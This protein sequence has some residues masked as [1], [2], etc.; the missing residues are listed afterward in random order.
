MHPD[1]PPIAAAPDEAAS[2]DAPG[3]PDDEQIFCP[4][5]GYNLTGNPTG[6]CSECGAL[7]SRDQ[8]LTAMKVSADALMPWE[9]R[10]DFG[11]FERFWRTL[12]ISFF[13]PREFAL[14][15]AVQPARTR[16]TSFYA[17]CLVLLTA[18]AT[19]IG[20]IT[21]MAEPGD[22]MDIARIAS[23][24]IFLALPIVPV[25]IVVGLIYASLYPHADR[26]R[27][28]RPWRAILEYATGH[29]LLGAS[30]LVLGLLLVSSPRSETGMILAV[31][32]LSIWIGCSILWAFTLVEIVRWRTASGHR[33]PR[34]L[35]P[36]IVLAWIVW[37]ATL[38]VFLLSVPLLWEL[39]EI[40]QSCVKAFERAAE[41]SL[42]AGEHWLRAA[43]Y[44]LPLFR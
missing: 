39:M 37:V 29:W 2:P 12:R 18:N 41:D 32:V 7:F 36:T 22:S 6:R 8:L 15:F 40:G 9:R 38:Y 1:D 14:A 35:G 26:E 21:E 17:V 33:K 43:R 42:R 11:P 19:A 20:V 3:R 27:H 4:V 23:F 10:D 13:R 44:F 30:A 25:N 34:G 28:L 16:S 31:C 24:P 5:C